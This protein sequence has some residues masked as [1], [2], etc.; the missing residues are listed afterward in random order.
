MVSYLVGLS[1]LRTWKG[2]HGNVPGRDVM[3]TYLVGLSW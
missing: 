1:W 3:V 2:C